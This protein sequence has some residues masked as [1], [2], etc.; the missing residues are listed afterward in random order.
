MSLCRLRGGA[1]NSDYDERSGSIAE[2]RAY[3]RK[4][5]KA[6]EYHRDAARKEVSSSSIRKTKSEDRSRNNLAALKSEV[7]QKCLSILNHLG[8]SADLKRI[9]D[10]WRSLYHKDYISRDCQVVYR[11]GEPISFESAMLMTGQVVVSKDRMRPHSPV[12]SLRPEEAATRRLT[13]RMSDKK[14]AADGSEAPSRRL[15]HRLHKEPADIRW[16]HRSNMRYDS[17][18]E[19]DSFN[20][21]ATAPPR[22]SPA[23]GLMRNQ[24]PDHQEEKQKPNHVEAARTSEN[25][26]PAEKADSNAQTD[27]DKSNSLLTIPKHLL[28]HKTRLC[29]EFMQKGS[30]QFERI[31]S[32]AHGKDELRSPFDTSKLAAIL[33]QTDRT[34]SG[35]VAAENGPENSTLSGKIAR[36]MASDSY[37]PDAHFCIS[38]SAPGQADIFISRRTFSQDLWLEVQ[39]W[40]NILKGQGNFELQVICQPHKKGSNNWRALSVSKGKYSPDPTSQPLPPDNETS[41]AVKDSST[42]EDII[43]PLTQQAEKS[44][45][46]QFFPE[47]LQP[48]KIGYTCTITSSGKNFSFAD[49]CIYIK[50]ELRDACGIKGLWVGDIVK[51]DA[52]YNLVRKNWVATSVALVQRNNSG[53]LMLQEA[54][55]KMQPH[56]NQDVEMKKFREKQEM[57][58]SVASPMPEAGGSAENLSAILKDP[59]MLQV[60]FLVVLF[61]HLNLGRLSSTHCSN[62]RSSTSLRINKR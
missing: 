50:N 33:T 3:S 18:M 4:L 13:G 45:V 56:A 62:T 52:A 26:V 58:T 2:A 35:P 43:A 51:I 57:P 48:P 27:T 9:V 21:H 36:V 17:P 28:L 24:N 30:C 12:Y 15:H 1:R 14:I 37:P 20:Q 11:S 46:S 39:R 29:R 59:E 8:G 22:S 61:A 44:T 23:S 7:A 49:D 55:D 19:E 53:Y 41:S 60:V 38:E 40:W 34:A 25:T 6:H 32:F 16:D 5:G 54:I 10:R 31:C 42:L 47:Q